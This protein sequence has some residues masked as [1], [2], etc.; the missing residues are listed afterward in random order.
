MPSSSLRCVTLS[1]ALAFCALLAGCGAGAS[2]DVKRAE[3]IEQPETVA[4]A[5]RP[6]GYIFKTLPRL[7]ATSEFVVRG[8]VKS[9]SKGERTVP[10][11]ISFKRDVVVRV[12]EQFHGPN[13]PSTIVVHVGGYNRDVPYELRELPWLYPGDRA[14]Y[15][16]AHAPEAPKNH[17]EIIGLPG[18]LVIEDDGT[19][20]TRAHDP[21][22]RKLDGEQ[23]RS[24]AKRLRGDV[25][26][27]QNQNI[28]P[29]PPGPFGQPDEKPK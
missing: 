29:L 10:D 22:A 21:I 11:G 8:T 2:P 26:T 13:L 6:P 25:R 1:T 17:Y 27:V 7:I 3:S 5:G 9:A 18:R 15:F 28:Q 4:D 23:W 19:V 24:I 20:S 16:L 12:E 14:V